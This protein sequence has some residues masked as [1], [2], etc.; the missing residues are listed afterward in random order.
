MS[1]VSSFLQMVAFLSTHILAIVLRFQSYLVD[2]HNLDEIFFCKKMKVAIK[3]FDI[4]LLQGEAIH[5]YLL[6]IKTTKKYVINL[7]ALYPINRYLE[8]SF[9]STNQPM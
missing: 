3:K 4:L 9:V 7:F 5:P 2:V 1:L 6:V 8:K